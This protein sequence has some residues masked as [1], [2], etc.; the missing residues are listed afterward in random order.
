[1]LIMMPFFSVYIIGAYIA[2]WNMWSPVAKNANFA[3]RFMFLISPISMPLLTL[4]LA[5]QT[6]L[7][8][9]QN[10]YQK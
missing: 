8:H 1:M 9:Y 7:D 3:T 5:T 4:T 6:L 10:R 2:G